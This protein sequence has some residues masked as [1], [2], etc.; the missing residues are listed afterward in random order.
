MCSSTRGPAIAPSL[1]TCPTSMIA[2]PL[3]LARRISTEADSRTCETEPGA[4]A[5]SGRYMV[6]IESTMASSGRSRSIC[7][8]TM[9]MSFSERT[10][11]SLEEAPSRRARILIWRVDSSPET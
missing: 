10:Y 1:V 8:S 4:L 3:V 5:S 6:W 2:Q 9:V 7:R 11:N